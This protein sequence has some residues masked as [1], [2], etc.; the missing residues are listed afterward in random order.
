M[1][2]EREDKLQAS[3]I[4]LSFVAFKTPRSNIWNVPSRFYCV[5][6]FFTFQPIMTDYMSINAGEDIKEEGRLKVDFPYLLIKSM[7][8]KHVNELPSASLDSIVTIQFDI[9][10][11]LSKI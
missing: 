5:L 9:D 1:A 2:I 10:E 4:S 3:K 6:R 7:T 8:R 11:S